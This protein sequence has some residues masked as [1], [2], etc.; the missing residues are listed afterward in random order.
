MM[1]GQRTEAERS[2]QLAEKAGFRVNPELKSDI[3]RISAK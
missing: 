2:V 1:S 3:R